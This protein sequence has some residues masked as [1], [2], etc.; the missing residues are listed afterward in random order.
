MKVYMGKNKHSKSKPAVG[1][2]ESTVGRLLFFWL[3]RMLLCTHKPLA[4]ALLL[5]L[6]SLVLFTH[7]SCESVL[8]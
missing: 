1:Y 6:I 4:S 7:L 3:A 8:E 5:Y 2:V